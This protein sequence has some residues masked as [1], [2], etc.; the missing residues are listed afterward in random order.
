MS[1][2]VDDPVHRARYSFRREGENLIVDTWLGGGGELP[3]HYHPVQVEN[4]HVVEGRVRFH[5][6]EVDRILEPKD[7]VVVV[8]PGMRHALKS[9]DPTEAHL[10]CEAIPALGLEAFLI[11]SS[12]AARQGLFRRGG[13]P[14]SLKGARWAASFLKSH[15]AE[16]VMT[17]PPQFAQRAMIALFAG[18]PD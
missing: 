11:D 2:T 3:K 18:R 9:V 8:E 6:D 4:W 7:G 16:T 17:F 15:R 12:A 1:E 13:I 14:A 10:R 5:L